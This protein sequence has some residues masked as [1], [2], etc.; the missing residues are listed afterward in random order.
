[1]KSIIEINIAVMRTC[2]FGNLQS[3][4]FFES[5][6]PISKVKDNSYVETPADSIVAGKSSIIQAETVLGLFLFVGRLNLKRGKKL[7]KWT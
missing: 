2:G 1:M 5:I 4:K 6:I 3:N 7:F